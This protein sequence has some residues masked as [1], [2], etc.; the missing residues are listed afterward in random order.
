ML[1]IMTEKQQIALT[2][3]VVGIIGLVLPWVTATFKSG[4]AGLMLMCIGGSLYL[5]GNYNRLPTTPIGDDPVQPPDNTNT[6]WC[7]WYK[8]TYKK[9]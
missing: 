1:R 5:V 8:E 3:K 6:E 9:Q 2:G 7:K 4:I